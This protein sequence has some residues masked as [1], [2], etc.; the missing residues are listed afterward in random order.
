[1][2]CLAPSDGTELFG[3]NFLL[4]EKLFN[5]EG[6][7]LLSARDV[8]ELIVFQLCRQ[9]ADEQMFERIINRHIRRKKDINNAFLRQNPNL[10]K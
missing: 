8:K 9:M 1:M 5:R 7:P 3:I 10:L 6:F 2:E 4:K